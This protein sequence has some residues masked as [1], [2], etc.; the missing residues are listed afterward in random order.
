M[1]ISRKDLRIILQA[2]NYMLTKDTTIDGA[3][4]QQSCE[5]CMSLMDIAKS[6]EVT[7]AETEKLCVI[8]RDCYENPDEEC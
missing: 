7:N 1:S 4:N 3:V 2:V 6:H 8:C 5:I